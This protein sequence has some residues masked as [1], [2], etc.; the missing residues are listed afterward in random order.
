LCANVGTLMCY[1]GPPNLYRGE[2]PEAVRLPRIET[3]V[4]PPEDAPHDLHRAISLF[5]KSTI[6]DD[7]HEAE[8]Y[9]DSDIRDLPVVVPSVIGLSDEVA[10]VASQRMQDELSNNMR[11]VVAALQDHSG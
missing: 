2:V 11:R 5:A 4:N 8:G 10:K 6:E 7:E 3:L 1:A 9:T